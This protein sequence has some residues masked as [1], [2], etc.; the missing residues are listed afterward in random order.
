MGSTSKS[1]G[2]ADS[3]P[4][5]RWA[6]TVGKSDWFSGAL[7]SAVRFRNPSHFG[8]VPGFRLSP[9]ACRVRRSCPTADPVF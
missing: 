5:M 8:F 7:G 9:G 3:A 4:A 6:V 2:E 1:R